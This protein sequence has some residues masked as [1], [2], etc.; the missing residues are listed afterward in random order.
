MN[1]AD[2]LIQFERRLLADALQTA[3]AAYWQRRAA[4][5]EAAKP[6]STD[7]RGRATDDDL[8]DAWRRCDDA[9]R[10]CRARAKAAPF[11][12]VR[13]EVDDALGEAA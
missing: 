11:D 12:D 7:Y 1:L 3:T 10:A 9:A 13:R 2:H 6:R 5:F 4:A 8:R